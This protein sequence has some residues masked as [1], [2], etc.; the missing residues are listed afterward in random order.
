MAP[1]IPQHVNRWFTLK[2][3]TGRREFYGI[4]PGQIS[5]SRPRMDGIPERDIP[6][7]T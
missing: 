5:G 4:D 3:Q 7:C 1:R 2:D 6:G